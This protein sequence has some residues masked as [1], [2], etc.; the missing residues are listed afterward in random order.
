MAK[1]LNDYDFTASRGR[2]EK[3]PWK[4]WA[5][6]SIWKLE[7][8]KDFDCKPASFQGAAQGAAKRMDMKVRTAV[9][10]KSV[11]VQFYN[12]K[13]AKKNA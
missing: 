4:D 11:I 12:E 6:G 3:Y 5:D 10:D 1:K 2:S 8:G 9:E 7:Q 13:E